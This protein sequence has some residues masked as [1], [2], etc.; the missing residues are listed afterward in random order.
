MVN[1]DV[2]LKKDSDLKWQNVKKPKKVLTNFSKN[3]QLSVSSLSTIMIRISTILKRRNLLVFKLELLLFLSLEWWFIMENILEASRELTK[4]ARHPMT[5]QEFHIL[6]F[7]SQSTYKSQ[8]KR[9]MQWERLMSSS[10]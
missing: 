9:E 3:W 10:I 5:L 4:V 2:S 7:K 6:K 1:Q 8:S